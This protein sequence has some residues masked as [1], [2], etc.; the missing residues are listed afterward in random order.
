MSDSELSD[1][2]LLAIEPISEPITEP[3][4]VPPRASTPSFGDEAND[5]ELVLLGNRSIRARARPGMISFLWLWQIVFAIFLTWPT[6]ALVGQAYGNHPRGDAV[7][8]EP[9]GLALAD[10]VWHA[11]RFSGALLAHDTIFAAFSVIGGLLPLSALLA[12]MTYTTRA[13]RSP[14][15]R[16]LAR[17]AVDAFG[18]MLALFVIAGALEVLFVGIAMM[19]GAY[20]SDSSLARLGEARAD[21]LGW[22]VSF[23]FF[24]VALAVG[25]LH[26]LARASV[27]RFRVGALKACRL[28]WNTFRRHPVSLFGSWGWR[29][30]AGL[31]PI[32]AASMVTDRIGL[33]PGSSLLAIFALHQVVVGARIALRASWLAS[34]LRA[35]DHAHRVFKSR[36]TSAKTAS[37][38]AA[39][40]GE[41]GA[42]IRDPA[43]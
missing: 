41:P 34:A 6:A 10:F 22:L 4:V 38:R 35:V 25:V 32:A 36:T 42:P 20:V 39:R 24:L 9:G 40:S 16:Q 5:A 11:R 43:A 33:K 23:L 7:L 28:A 12:S 21:Q 30:A 31:V 13:R 19:L 37:E 14:R 8:F 3:R 15:P 26:D 27:V 18:R 29:A 2:D 17:F 1:S